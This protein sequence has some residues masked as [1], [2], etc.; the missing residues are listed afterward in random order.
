[1]KNRKLLYLLYETK[2][3]IENYII[4]PKLDGNSLITQE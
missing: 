2:P 4:E 3:K 1:M